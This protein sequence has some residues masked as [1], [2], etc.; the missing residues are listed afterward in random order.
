MK[1]LR[2]YLEIDKDVPVDIISDP[3]K[4]KNVL[5]NILNNSVKYTEK[6]CIKVSIRTK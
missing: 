4:L 2:F 6:G 3:C 1:C 5:L